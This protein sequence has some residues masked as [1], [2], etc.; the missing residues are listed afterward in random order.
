[1]AELFELDENSGIPLWV[2]L[3]NRLTYLISV[4]HYHADDQL[5]TVRGL[6]V[7]AKINYNTV[8]KVYQSLERDGYIVTRRGLGTFVCDLSKLG[9]AAPGSATD[10]MIDEFLR[11][12]LGLGIPLEDIPNQVKRRIKKMKAE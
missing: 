1:M 7:D 11:R 4:G 2:Q 3:R 9:A 12:S 10:A 5:P 8:N 6:A